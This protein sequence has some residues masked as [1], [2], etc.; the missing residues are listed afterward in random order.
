[1]ENLQTRFKDGIRV[2]TGNRRELRFEVLEQQEN[3]TEFVDE[4][5]TMFVP[6]STAHAC[7]TLTNLGSSWTHLLE[8]LSTRG[9]RV[10]DQDAIETKRCHA[11]IDPAC[12]G[13]IT[14]KLGLDH[15]HKR[16]AIP[17]F[18]L[19]ANGGPNLRDLR[20]P[21]RHLT[22]DERTTLTEHLDTQARLREQISPKLLTFMAHGNVFGKLDVTHSQVH[23]FEIREGIKLIEIWGEDE[24]G[25]AL[26]ATHSIRYRDWQGIVPETATFDLGH[27]MQLWLH[28]TPQT[29]AG[30]P[31]GAVVEVK[32]RR[33][34]LVARA[35]DWLSSSVVW[36]KPWPVYAIAGLLLA[37]GMTIGWVV[38]KKRSDGALAK[39]TAQIDQ[40]SKELASLRA[41]P[42]QSAIRPGSNVTAFTLT[43][44]KISIR[45][46]GKS[47]PVVS[48]PP[49]ATLVLLELP[50]YEQ[51]PLVY[52]AVLKPFLENKE[53]IAEDGLSAKQMDQHLMV[54]FSLPTSL[55]ENNT[56]YVLHLHSKDPSGHSQDV[57][58]FTFYVEKK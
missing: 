5:L 31:T 26:L 38:G 14:C 27:K 29:A 57:L 58:N 24:T 49:N 4:C 16:L 48:I 47:E 41:G 40:M 39:Q 52:R 54:T 36:G 8:F 23:S 20:G 21:A 25:K 7:P 43:P 18:F 53:I 51:R 6:W 35:E 50:I 15:P 28:I 55:V 9:Y 42:A 34:G 44:D 19:Y 22:D 2:V 11:F 46:N 33:S 32:Y 45:E 12:Y 56:D 3:W 30:E 10:A 13:E 17:K 37:M 1:M